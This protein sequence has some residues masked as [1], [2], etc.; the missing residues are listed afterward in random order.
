MIKSDTLSKYGVYDAEVDAREFC[1][2]E[3][4]ERAV[5]WKRMFEKTHTGQQGI[6]AFPSAPEPVVMSTFISQ[7]I[8]LKQADFDVVCSFIM[9]NQTINAIKHVRTVTGSGLKESKDY[10]DALRK[11]M[12][13]NALVSLEVKPAPASLKELL[14]AINYP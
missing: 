9:G 3:W 8:Q 6:M 5:Y 14:H 12:H 11:D 4:Y 13:D 2:A 1:E 7:G 10:I